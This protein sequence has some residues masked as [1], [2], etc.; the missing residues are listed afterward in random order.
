MIAF[1]ILINGSTSYLRTLSNLFDFVIVCIAVISEVYADSSALGAF[2]T[3][4][5][6]RILRPLRIV[7]RSE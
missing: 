3:L 4:R 2:K 1:G 6:C 5:V 7:S